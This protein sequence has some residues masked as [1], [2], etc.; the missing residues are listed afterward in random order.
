M[1]PAV[2]VSREIHANSRCLER[3]LI[4]PA[5]L[6]RQV[7]QPDPTVFVLDASASRTLSVRS[8]E[9]L[10]SGITAA[11]GNEEFAPAAAGYFDANQLAT[12]N[13]L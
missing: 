9:L 11:R 8:Y 4:R 5:G 1:A 7:T 2:S 13:E 6:T 10:E 3:I 12:T